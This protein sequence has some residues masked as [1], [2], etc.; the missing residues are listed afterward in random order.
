M[1]QFV[2]VPAKYLLQSG[3]ETT[4]T[5]VPVLFSG[6]TL[7]CIWVNVA[8]SFSLMLPPSLFCLFQ[9]LGLFGSTQWKLH[10]VYGVVKLAACHFGL[11]PFWAGYFCAVF[12]WFAGEC[13]PD[14]R[15]NQYSTKQLVFRV[16]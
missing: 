6:E 9:V 12:A 8:S 5:S 4:H 2:R 3:R 7:K 10:L 16:F 11:P 13:W 15:L 14:R 1:L